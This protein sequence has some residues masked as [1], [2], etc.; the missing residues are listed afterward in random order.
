LIAVSLNISCRKNDL[1]IAEKTGLSTETRFIN[2][3]RSNDPAEKAIVEYVKRINTQ[4]PFIEETIKRIGYPYWD[5]TVKHT[6][7]SSA[8]LVSTFGTRKTHDIGESGNVDIYYVPFV[9]DSQNYVNASMVIRTTHTDTS[10]SYL[11]DWQ[12]RTLPNNQ[13][14]VKDSAE[15]LSVFFMVLDNKVFGHTQFKIIDQTLFRTGQ[16][17]PIEITLNTQTK[18]PGSHTLSAYVEFCQDVT[19]SYAQGQCWYVANNRTCGNAPEGTCDICGGPLCM[20][21]GTST[22]TYC[23]GEWVD[24]GGSS[25]TGG[26]DIGGSDTGPV[27]PDPCDPTP[28]TYTPDAVSRHTQ[29]RISTFSSPCDGGP[30]WTPTSIIYWTYSGDDGSSFIDTDPSKEVDLQFDTADHIDTQYPNL[31]QLAKNLKSFVKGSPE[32]LAALQHWSGFSKQQILDKLTFGSGPIIK[33]VEGLDGFS[34]YNK[35]TGEN[36]L[37]ISASWVRGLETAVLPATKQGTAFI[38]AV[39][40]LHEFV[41]YG[42]GQ[43]NINEG[44]YDFGWGFERSAFSVIVNENNANEISIKFKKLI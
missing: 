5:K 43:H 15:Y 42:T 12:Y 11:C 40:L 3:H 14:Q 10:I 32:V 26:G 25:G 30:G 1:P 4:T 8:S 20:S 29:S 36:I 13:Q 18:N 34:S 35:K 23:W 38:I 33:V 41:H 37:K 19:V 6:A 44:D 31:Y 28:P 17:T 7:R 39:S 16:N 22:Y 27:P 9:R 2:S 24:S 21:I